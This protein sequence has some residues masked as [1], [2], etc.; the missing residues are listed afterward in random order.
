M[1]INLYSLSLL[2]GATA[3]LLTNPSSLAATNKIEDAVLTPKMQGV[4]LRLTTNNKNT[5]D[6]SFMTVIEDNI[7][8][9]T[10]LDTEL[11]LSHQE[12]FLQTTPAQGIEQISINEIG[13][14]ST[15]ITFTSTPNMSLEPTIETQGDDLIFGLNPIPQSDSLLSRIPFLSNVSSLK[16][17]LPSFLVSQA[18]KDDQ[19]SDDTE[20]TLSNSNNNILVPDPEIIIGESVEGFDNGLSTDQD[21][22]EEYLPRAVAPPVG[23]IAVSNISTFADTIDLG[24]SAMIPRLV[25]R[26]APV[27][28]V[29]SLL[30]RQA[31]LN[32]VF[33]VSAEDE[34][35]EEASSPEGPTISLDLENQSVQ[36]VFDSIMLISGLNASRRGNI[37]YIGAKLPA[38]ARN[39]IS[40]TLRL[41][42]VRA[43]NAALFLA[44][45]GAQGQRL[46]TEVEETVD[47]ETGRVVQR[48]ELP[49]SLEDLGGPAQDEE[50][51]T[52]ALLL[53]GLQIAT[54]DRLNSITLVGEPRKVETATAFIT[55]LDARR[56]QVAV[57]VKILDVNLDN[58]DLFNSSFSFGVNDTFFIQD[59]GA[60]TLRFGES[61]PARSADINSAQGRVTNP[62]T[63]VNP[64]AGANT[65][66]DLNNT[67]GVPGTLPGLIDGN[68]GQ[69][70]IPRGTGNFFNRNI[71]A[72]SNPFRTGLTDFTLAEDGTITFNDDGTSTFTAGTDGTATFGLPSLFQYPK[73]FLAQLEA[74][75]T[76]GNA[77]ILTDPTLVVQEGQQATVKLAQNVIESV[78]TEIDGDSGT[79][80]ITPVIVEAGLVLTVN[81]ERIDDNGFIGLSVS[82]TVSSIGSTQEFD[83][84]AGANNIL[85]LLS[86]R[87][88][89]SGLIRLRDGQ[90]LILSGI[91]QD[92][93]RSTVSKVPILGDIPLLGSLFRSSTKDNERAEVIVLLTPQVI[94]EQSGFGYNYTPGKEAREMLRQGGLELP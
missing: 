63:I 81:V 12:D 65:F 51:N 79:R 20:K 86:K 19:K 37:I 72:S 26:D 43:E 39:L 85:S 54:D 27:R 33:S 24:S 13:E 31:G 84:G 53:R 59:Q 52:S 69:V 68:T 91:I 70:L 77:K 90:T 6:T 4:E 41:N 62:P 32:V 5:E 7:V 28:E 92:Q 94:D 18:T 16:S 35:A 30:S 14:G 88:V 44:S 87:E 48:R 1:K 89:S 60:A 8:K 83:S 58:Q 9:T 17:K 76:S 67:T 55:Q 23:D 15:Q 38:Q 64:L 73:Q 47:P 34:E 57:N 22:E 78:K 46:T 42:Q 49:A 40:R 74:Q 25:L 11:Q 80:T 21:P 50:D 10:I 66:I 29:L 61:A 75:I 93:E 71:D 2:T 3:V 36:E 82:P 45:Q 56:R